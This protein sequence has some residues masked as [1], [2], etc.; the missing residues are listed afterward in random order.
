MDLY[1]YIDKNGIPFRRL[2]SFGIQLSENDLLNRLKLTSDEQVDYIAQKGELIVS[3]YK[4]QINNRPD[5]PD[6]FQLNRQE[7]EQLAIDWLK[8]TTG[9]SVDSFSTLFSLPMLNGRPFLI[10]LERRGDNYNLFYLV[11]ATKEIKGDIIV[12]EKYHRH[13]GVIQEN[14]I[15]TFGQITKIHGNVGIDGALNDFG[16]LKEVTGDLWFSNHVYQENLDSIHPLSIVGGDLNLKNTHCDLGSLVEVKGNLNLRKTS[17]RNLT[18]LKYVGGN[19]LLSKSQKEHFDFNSV[20]IKGKIKSF[21][22]SFNE[23][24]LTLPKYLV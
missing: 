20:E 21:N 23:R 17:S 15:N 24:Q 6:K 12:R 14:F 19:I 1:K 9:Y 4:S 16:E 8:D 3:K 5:F 18:S 2:A 11:L 10:Q 13:T 7:Q 22:D